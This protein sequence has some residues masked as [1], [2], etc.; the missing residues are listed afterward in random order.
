MFSLH[1]HNLEGTLLATGSSIIWGFYWVI[2]L[3]DERNPLIKLLTSFIIGTTLAGIYLLLSDGFKIDKPIYILGAVY[4]GIFEMGITFFLWL[5]ALTLSKNN[6]GIASLAYLAP[7]L[8]LIFIYFVLH[9]NITA[10]AITGLVFIISGILI[11][12][13]KTIIR[14]RSDLSRL[15]QE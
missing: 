10:S 15:T 12:Q 8:S 2:N 6:A 5:K 14:R 11:Q 9:E 4:T 3:M 7:F 13:I 1:F